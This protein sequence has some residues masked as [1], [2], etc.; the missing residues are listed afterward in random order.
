MTLFNRRTAKFSAIA[1]SICASLL[2]GC[3][4]LSYQEPSGDNTAT[5]IFATDNAAVQ[6]VICVPGKGFESSS[7]SVA[8]KSST[9]ETLRELH[10]AL[11]KAEQV[12]V[13]VDATRSSV[14]VGFIM[15]K[16]NG[17]GPRKHCKVAAQL[18]ISSGQT[19]YATFT[20]SGD[21][22]GISLSDDKG[23][24]LSD[25]IITPYACQ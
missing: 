9:N 3:Q 10:E 1:I 16:K 2:S 17:A 4:M 25:A 20:A 5:V 6:P 7:F 24:S 15:Q 18:S 14:R 13:K 11:H 22:C 19:Y 8:R 12:S 21:T 23:A